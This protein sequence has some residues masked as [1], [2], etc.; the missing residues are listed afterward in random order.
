MACVP[1]FIKDVTTGTTDLGMWGAYMCG[2]D[3]HVFA[4]RKEAC[5]QAVL[6]AVSYLATTGADTKAV[7]A[8]LV[9]YK[10]GGR[11]DPAVK[12]VWWPERYKLIRDLRMTEEEVN[13]ICPTK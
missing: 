6:N 7:N 11:C 10:A 12:A 4:C 2:K 9:K 1:S 5:T 3:V 13:A 8:G